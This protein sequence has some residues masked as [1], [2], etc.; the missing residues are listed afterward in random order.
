MSAT[1]LIPYDV[2][3]E[4]LLGPGTLKYDTRL[5]VGNSPDRNDGGC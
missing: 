3:C 2:L 1:A 4:L 5:G